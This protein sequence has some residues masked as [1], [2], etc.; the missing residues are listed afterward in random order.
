VG[1][2]LPADRM[3]PRTPDDH[4]MISRALGGQKGMTK[5]TFDI[6][7]FDDTSVEVERLRVVKSPSGVVHAR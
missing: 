4:T 7:L 2:A 6:L 3:R 1:S 5:I